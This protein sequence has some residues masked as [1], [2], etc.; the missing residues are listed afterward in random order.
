M[1]LVIHRGRARVGHLPL[2]AAALLAAAGLPLAAASLAQQFW[3]DSGSL[4]EWAGFLSGAAA[5]TAAVLLF[6]WSKDENG[7]EAAASGLSG[8]ALF[9][10]VGVQKE[11]AGAIA[12]S[13]I[14][15]LAVASLAWAFLGYRR[16]SLSALVPAV[17]L[18]A[19]G[20]LSAFREED[21]SMLPA[22]V[23]GLTAVVAG[24]GALI[25]EA[26]KDR[27]KGFQGLASVVF[28][29]AM[30]AGIAVVPDA[31][32]KLAEAA[33]IA[34]ASAVLALIMDWAFPASSRHKI[35]AAILW[36]SAATFAFSQ[37][38][39]YGL[40]LAAFSAAVCLVLARRSDLLP[41]LAPLGAFSLYR[42]YLEATDNSAR[43][44]DIGQHYGMIG[45][46]A[47]VLV[48]QAAAS[49]LEGVVCDCKVPLLKGILASL[50]LGFALLAGGLVLG[51]K[52][53]TGLMIGA[54]VP[55]VLL[56]S[57]KPRV[58]LAAFGIG[59]GCAATV[60]LSMKGL[61]PFL[62]LPREAKQT[63]LIALGLLAVVPAAAL[64]LLN[65]PKTQE[66]ANG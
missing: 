1:S 55:G 57:E 17:F 14:L 49:L 34:V 47:G 56:A 5:A 31:A 46:L 50:F 42:L 52:G 59:I 35:V 24:G 6:E 65:R 32:G 4:L 19:A 64:V 20:G 61:L 37:L 29:G 7:A 62:D 8:V 33:A 63:A 18:A 38:Q 12:F 51:D 43:A 40:A 16:S 45:L 36:L 13:Y 30:A 39:G 66:A 58:G 28:F 54:L 60:A 22:M 11:L 27:L 15:G 9:L 53:I 41:T 10:L 44:F 23:L 2:V 21:A 48:V 25:F 3:P 26:I